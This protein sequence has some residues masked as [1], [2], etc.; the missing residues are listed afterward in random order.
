[1]SY[2]DFTLSQLE[3]DFQLTIY[4]RIKVFADVEPVEISAFLSEI[5][6]ENVPL[7]LAIHTEKARSEM[8]I[9]PILIE[10]RKLVNRKI[11]LFSGVDFSV[12]YQKNLDG[13]CDF[14][15]SKSEEQ[16]F[17]KFPIIIIVEAKNENIKNGLPQ[18]L[19][20]MVAAQI[21][22]DKENSAVTDIYGAVTTGNS[23]KFLKLQ[24]KAIFIDI[25]DYYINDPGKIMSNLLSMVE[26][27]DHT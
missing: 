27:G 13:I 7:A 25:D 9:A 17:I 12:D 3:R 26:H 10:L 23:W 21:F 24:G 19:S 20:A 22:N 6:A 11:S 2:S 15:I 16:F 4:E 14:I 5:L 18:C 8:I 1:M